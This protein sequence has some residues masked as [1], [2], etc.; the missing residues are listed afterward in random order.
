MIKLRNKRQLF[1]AVNIVHATSYELHPYLCLVVFYVS[2]VSYI[3]FHW[4]VQYVCYVCCACALYMYDSVLNLKQ[5]GHILFSAFTLCS[6][7]SYTHMCISSM[8]FFNFF[9]LLWQYL[10]WKD[11]LLK[12]LNSHPLH[13]LL[14]L[15]LSL[16]PVCQLRNRK[17]VLLEVCHSTWLD[18]RVYWEDMGNT[19]QSI[20]K[21]QLNNAYILKS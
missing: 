2:C 13:L 16:K 19:Q 21:N 12:S 4:C 9:S 8:Y 14:L 6:N 5:L 1:R 10:K 11:P 15:S 7:L 17:W 20:G 3:W 18:W